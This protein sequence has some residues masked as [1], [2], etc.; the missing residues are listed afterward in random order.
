M[1]D[2]EKPEPNGYEVERA[3]WNTFRES[4]QATGIRIDQVLAEWASEEAQKLTSPGAREDFDELCADGCSP[5]VLAAIAAVFR[6][7]PRSQRFWAMLVGP[8][9]DRQ[10]TKRILE[11]AAATLEDIF[12]AFIAA[13]DEKDRA[14]F[15]KLGRIPLSRLVAELRFHI[16]FINS[17]ES[18][19]VDTE[20]HSLGEVSKYILSSYVKR[21]TG[22]F[23]DR[24][25]SGLI[26]EIIA[27]PDYNEVAHRMWRNRNYERLEKHFS[28]ITEFLVAMSVVIAHPA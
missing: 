4:R 28:R 10:K 11:N 7:S 8:P 5:Q 13:E 14:Q 6:Y 21:R 15:A 22:R 19:A 24:N 2:T 20:A 26:G 25:V 16:R 12:G 9:E 27:S 1:T 23:H 3:F 18:L 17:A